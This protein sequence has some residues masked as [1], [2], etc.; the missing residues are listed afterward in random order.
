MKILLWSYAGGIMVILK[1]LLCFSIFYS[2]VLNM[3]FKNFFYFE[4]L[5]K[6]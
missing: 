2:F 4:I 1:H 6:K 3:A 5:F